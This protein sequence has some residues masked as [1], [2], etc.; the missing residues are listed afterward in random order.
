MPS[1]W[2]SRLGE[3]VERGSWAECVN[4]LLSSG[5]DDALYRGQRCFDW[6]LRASLE[7]V[8]LTYAEQYDP[9]LHELM[10]SMSADSA[11]EKRVHDVE[12][13]L[14]QRFRQRAMHFGL[15]G[16]PEA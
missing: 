15:P 11:T 6:E 16:L 13:E 12:L 4:L 7:R 2:A 1:G 10:M 5:G 3:D 14:M 8:L 9:H